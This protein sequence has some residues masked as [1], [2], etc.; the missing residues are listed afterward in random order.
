[1]VCFSTLIAVVV[2]NLTRLKHYRA[3]PW[4]I[5]KHLDGRFGEILLLHHVT[6]SEVGVKMHII[7]PRISDIYLSLQNV[8][9]PRVSE[10]RE[11]PFDEHD[12]MQNDEQQ[13]IQQC[14]IGKNSVQ[15]DYL[16][17]A[18]AIDR[19]AFILYLFLFMIFGISYSL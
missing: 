1:M 19:I 5:K 7:K 17:L 2:I 8:Q 4:I 10:L 9:Q 16:K 11:H 14:R 6:N 13:I 15:S 12:S 18:T 3:L